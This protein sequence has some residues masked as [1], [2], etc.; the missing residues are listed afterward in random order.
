[1]EKQTIFTAQSSNRL[2]AIS[3]LQ[4]RIERFFEYEI[5]KPARTL[6]QLGKM[7]EKQESGMVMV[8]RSAKYIER[9][10]TIVDFLYDLLF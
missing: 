5:A 2:V 8:Q 9:N 1:M 6:I 7:E 4:N 10:Y 3:G